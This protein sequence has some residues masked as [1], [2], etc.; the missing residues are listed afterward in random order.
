MSNIILKVEGLDCA[1][2]AQNLGDKICKIKNVKNADVSIITNKLNIQY[3]NIGEIELICQVRE[4]AESMGIDIVDN[5]NPPQR[6]FG[7]LDKGLKIRLVRY[8]IGGIMYLAALLATNFGVID[9]SGVL[10]HEMWGRSWSLANWLFVA[11]YVIF[12]ADILIRAVRGIIKRDVFNENFHMSIATICAI[13]IGLYYEAVLVMIFF[14]VGEFFQDMAVNR[15]R[16]SI[17]DI[18]A[19]SDSPGKPT[20]NV[21][22]IAMAG[23]WA[24]SFPIMPFIVSPRAPLP[25]RLSMSSSMCWMGMSMYGQTLGWSIASINPSST[26]SG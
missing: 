5:V 11:S 19:P 26:P 7:G 13:A 17:S 14:Q 18:N 21:L 12:G 25:M 4:E 3:E 6:A 16:K 23:T 24:L 2:C 1:H 22:R 10:A 15:S 20:I 9:L 8:F